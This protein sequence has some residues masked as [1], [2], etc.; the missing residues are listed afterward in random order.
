MDTDPRPNGP[1][2]EPDE[3]LLDLAERRDADLASRH[4]VGRSHA[5]VMDA[6]RRAAGVIRP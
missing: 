1:V 3:D 6:A 5:E 4:V 2:P